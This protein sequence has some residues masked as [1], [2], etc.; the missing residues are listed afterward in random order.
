MPSRFLEKGL[1]IDKR[2][3]LGWVGLG[4]VLGREGKEKG[5]KLAVRGGRK[6]VEEREGE[7]GVVDWE[8]G[9]EEG[10]GVERGED[11]E[12]DVKGLRDEVLVSMGGPSSRSSSSSSSSSSRPSSRPSSRSSSSSSSLSSS[13]SSTTSS[14]SS[15]SS[16]SS[17]SRF[18]LSN[19]TTLLTNL[20]LILAQAHTSSPSSLPAA[21]RLYSSLSPLSPSSPHCFS[22]EALVGI[23]EIETMVCLCCF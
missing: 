23:A 12:G 1:D 5:C 13:S 16:S 10:G 4:R 20:T 18:P 8:R 17:S 19:H 11:E 15:S 7:K 6:A 14:L 3:G 2:S 22:V 9:E 21:L